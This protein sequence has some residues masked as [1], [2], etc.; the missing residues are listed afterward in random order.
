MGRGGLLSQAPVRSD[1]FGRGF[2]YKDTEGN[3]LDTLSN[4]SD[5]FWTKTQ[6]YNPFLA[7]RKAKEVDQ[8]KKKKQRR[9]KMEFNISFKDHVDQDGGWASLLEDICA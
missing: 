3:S 6:L 4:P 7:C 9:E 5:P 2:I 1:D 8:K